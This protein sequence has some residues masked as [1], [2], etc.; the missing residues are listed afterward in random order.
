MALLFCVLT[1]LCLALSFPPFSLWPFAFIAPLGWALVASSDRL[2]HHL[3]WALYASALLVWLWLHRWMIG[4]TVAGYPVLCGYLALYAL[5]GVWV[6]RRTRHGLIGRYLP[7]AIRLPAVLIALEWLQGTVIFHGYPW[8]AFAQPLIDFPVVAQLAD[9]GGVPLVTLLV[10]GTV[11]VLVDLLCLCR[12]TPDP[13]LRRHVVQGGIGVLLAWVCAIAYGSHRLAEWD[14]MQR[15]S[16]PMS[17]LRVAVVQTNVP[18]S[19]KLRWSRQQQEDAAASFARATI[20]LVESSQRDGAIDFVVWPETMLPGFGLEPAT[21]RTLCDG[22]WWPENRFAELVEALVQR[23]NV[24]LVVGS[25]VYI[26]LRENGD[27][28]NWSEHF[29]SAYLVQGD[30]PYQRYDK[31][32]LT[33]FGEVMPYISNWKWLEERLLAIGAAGMQFDLDEALVPRRL[34]LQR[35]NDAR[36]VAPKI[37]LALATPI[38]FEDTMSGEVRRIVH[39]DAGHKQAAILVNLSNDGWF[40]DCDSGRRAHELLAR[41]RCIENR[42][43]MVR[44]A[45][46]GISAA[47]D[48]RGVPIPNA[49]VAPRTAG[50]FIAELPL[51]DRQ[52]FFGEFGNVLSPAMALMVAIM[53]VPGRW[54]APTGFRLFVGACALLLV[55]CSDESQPRAVFSGTAWSSRGAVGI[56]GDAP[57]NPDSG[58]ASRLASVPSTAPV[59]NEAERALEPTPQPMDT[60]SE[61]PAVSVPAQVSAAP[62]AP[63]PTPTAAPTPAPAAP[64]SEVAAPA[65]AEAP[66]PAPPPPPPPQAPPQPPPEAPPTPPSPPQAK[67]TFVGADA[68][69]QMA[70]DLIARAASSDAAILRSHALEALQTR[71]EAL[72]EVACKMLGDPSPGV[73]FAA[74]VMI[75]KKRLDRCTTLLQP[76]LLDPNP[77]VQASALFALARLGQRMDLGPLLRLAMSEDPETRSNAFFV[78]GELRNPTAIPLIEA[79]IGRPLRTADEVRIRIVELQAAEAMCKMGDYRQYDPIRAALFAPSEQAELIALACQMVGE[80]NDRGARGSLIGIWNGRGSM[81]RPMEIRLLTGTALVRIGEPNVEPIYLLCMKAIKDPSGSIRA[82]A[83]STLG[84]IGGTRAADAVAPLM[85]ENDS[86]VSISAAAAFLRAT[87]KPADALPPIG[88][89]ESTTRVP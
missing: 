26:G 11:G 49:A 12:G 35:P 86:L 50:G 52:S 69:E 19:N 71:P 36:G 48:S 20:D 32:H 24:P 80:V 16:Q 63:A 77:S 15:A 88:A 57:V 82:Q 18:T 51:D 21:L 79:C 43:P 73:R 70:F 58:R 5:A 17:R 29:N 81:E 74:A 87:A 28:W 61:A 4:V 1:P 62:V 84:W 23:I 60:G 6:M 31:I 45:N 30:P 25:P 41:W 68:R 13:T 76:L 22:Q 59:E 14:A 10:A 7:R 44:A 40:G 66:A 55:G 83:A 67:F 56:G 27:R 37:G 33:P 46:T 78:L 9:I 85:Q 2:P 39:D 38:C 64:P 47:F 3:W 89:T 34:T 54:I 65:P 8:Y 72:A 75:G 53:V 42:L